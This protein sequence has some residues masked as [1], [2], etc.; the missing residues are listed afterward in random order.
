MGPE[1]AVHKQHTCNPYRG[2]DSQHP[3][4]RKSRGGS[5]TGRADMRIGRMF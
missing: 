5:D 2:I 3:V 4:A 1:V